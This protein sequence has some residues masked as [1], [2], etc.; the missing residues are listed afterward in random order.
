VTIRPWPAGWSRTRPAALGEAL[1]EEEKDQQLPEGELHGREDNDEDKVRPA[2]VDVDLAG[3]VSGPEPQQ[4]FGQTAD[5][6]IPR[7]SES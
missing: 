3:D 4:S 1:A 5:A 6:D 7:D 2:G